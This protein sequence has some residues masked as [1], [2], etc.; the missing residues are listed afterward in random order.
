[1]LH[2]HNML[3]ASYG[4]VTILAIYYLGEIDTRHFEKQHELVSC[5]SILNRTVS[6][7]KLSSTVSPS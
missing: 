4:R 5:F 3:D 1:M 6:I 2:A 7:F